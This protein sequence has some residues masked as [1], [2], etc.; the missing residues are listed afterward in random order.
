MN[1]KLVIYVVVGLLL[2]AGLFVL[3]RPKTPPVQS[4]QGNTTTNNS[5]VPT[6][7]PV[8]TKKTFE[9]VIQNKKLVSGPET[10][11]VNE[12]D[13]VVVK[14]TSDIDEE[15][16]LHGYDISTE[17]VKGEPATLSFKA[18]LTG[19]FVYELEKS[20]VEI[21]VLEVLPK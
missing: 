6:P 20:S 3:V 10:I 7:P 8:S 13:D 2:L 19:R 17:L 18:N 5:D 21:G 9:L 11:Q 14:I 12:G 16:H 15:L 4:G 1:N